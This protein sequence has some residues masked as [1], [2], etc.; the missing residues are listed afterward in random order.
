M[1]KKKNDRRAGSNMKVSYFGENRG[2]SRGPSF[3]SFL[4]SCVGFC[5]CVFLFLN[6]ILGDLVSLVVFYVVIS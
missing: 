2:H 6:C 1:G 4:I 5:V 3:F